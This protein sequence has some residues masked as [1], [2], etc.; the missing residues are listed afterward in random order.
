MQ[1]RPPTSGEWARVV[2]AAAVAFVLVAAWPGMTWSPF[3]IAV[4]AYWALPAGQRTS[5][6]G[7]IIG[8]SVGFALT[9]LGVV[10]RM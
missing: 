6:N 8:W 10:L 7:S 1:Q 3:V 9:M 2:M 4:A 5:R